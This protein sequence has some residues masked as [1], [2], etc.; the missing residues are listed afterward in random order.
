[1]FTFAFFVVGEGRL[2]SKLCVLLQLPR[3]VCPCPREATPCPKRL[4]PP[5]DVFPT[6]CL[7]AQEHFYKR[8][9][10]R[11]ACTKEARCTSNST[12]TY[13]GAVSLNCFTLFWHW[14][15]TMP[16]HYK[17]NHS[18]KEVLS[19]LYLLLACNYPLK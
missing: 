1:M 11:R 12:R 5:C 18:F 4:P 7:Q 2:N 17:I 19:K 3:C 15:V 13:T 10:E 9:R 16:T 14:Q 6:A 8:Q